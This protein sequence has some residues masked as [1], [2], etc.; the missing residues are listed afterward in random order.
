MPSPYDLYDYKSYWTDRKYEHEAET[1]A[2]KHFFASLSGRA[3]C[4]EV[5]SG[6]GRLVKIYHPFCSQITLL[7][8]S[9]R[10]LKDARTYLEKISPRPKFVQGKAEKLPFKNNSFG[11]IV[12]VRVLHHLPD[13]SLSLKEISRVLKPGGSLILEFAN[14]LHLK[15][16]LSIPLDRF[17]S[18]LTSLKP[19]ERRSRESIERKTIPFVNHHPSLIE[20]LLFQNK[21]RIVSKR[22]VSNL[23]FPLFKHLLPLTTLTGLESVLQNLSTKTGVYLGPSIFIHAKKI[24]T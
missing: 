8:P 9:V 19:I 13:P 3:D 14:K 20:S 10:N 1:I 7:D 11:C 4:L 5:G 23:R 24:G 12:M 17:G 6:Y 18:F 15:N 21:F 2:I 22:S 16:L